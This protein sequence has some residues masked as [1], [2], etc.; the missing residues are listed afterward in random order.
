[1]SHRECQKFVCTNFVNGST[2]LAGKKKE[3]N[4]NKIFIGIKK[5]YCEYNL[6]YDI[7]YKRIFSSDSFALTTT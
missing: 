5:N 1:M 3:N 2:K 7:F 6:K 4:T